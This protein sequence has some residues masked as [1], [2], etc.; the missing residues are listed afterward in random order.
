ML[1]TSNNQQ[2]YDP[3]T[4]AVFGGTIEKE[5]DQGCGQEVKIDRI[6]NALFK[7]ITVN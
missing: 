6:K 3:C 4:G 5:C 7:N 2:L 1:I